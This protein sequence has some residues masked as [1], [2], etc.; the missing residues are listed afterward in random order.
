MIKLQGN[1]MKRAQSENKNMDYQSFQ[2]Y[3]CNLK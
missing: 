2:T 1:R 3:I